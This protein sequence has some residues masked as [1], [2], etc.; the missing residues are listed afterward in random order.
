MNKSKKASVKS[1]G[2]ST[3][4]I[5]LQY[6]DEGKARVMDKMLSGYDIVGR[7]NGGPNAGHTLSVK[8]ITISLHQVPSGIFYKNMML[9][10]GSGCVVNPVK[11]LKEITEIKSYNIKIDGRLSI[12]GYATLIQPYHIVFDGIYGKCIGSTKNGIGAAYADQAIRACGNELKNIRLGDYL[13]NPKIFKELV[14]NNL[15]KIILE[16]DIK[17][18]D[19]DSEIYQFH[20]C[21]LDLKKYLCTDPL[22]LEKMVSKGKNIF[23]EGAQSIMLD[24]MY[25]ATPYVTSS[26]TVAGAAYTGGDLSMRYHDKTIGVAKAIMSRVGNGPFISEYGGDRS[27][28]YCDE[29][30]GMAHTNEKEKRAHNPKSLLKS[31]E[32]FDIGMA[33]RMMTGEYGATTKR[34]RRIGMLDLVMLRQ[35]CRLNGV[36][37]LYINKIDCLQ[38]FS[39]TKLKGIPFVTAYELNGKRINHM[40][41]SAEEMRRCKPIIKYLPTFAEDITN[42]KNAKNLSLQVKN[43]IRFIEKE[44]GT[45]IAGIGVGPEREQFVM[46]K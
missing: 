41:S 14:K 3:I 31:T 21:V 23:F 12:S 2:K 10:I 6:G 30:G 28:K 1:L 25:G 34:P 8:D 11:L 7:F 37:E 18:I 40:P 45:K 17:D 32:M 29:D 27:E 44:V 39:Q 36:E 42:M 13:A 33:F 35:N 46:L 19:I 15:K 38:L 22:I 16:H 20:N 24:V 5:G 43:I 26:R 4:L 9:H